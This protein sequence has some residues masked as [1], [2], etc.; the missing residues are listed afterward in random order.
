MRRLTVLIAVVALA[1]GACTGGLD[2]TFSDIGAETD[3]QPGTDSGRSED[4]ATAGGEEAAATGTPTD[5]VDASDPGVSEA[6]LADGRD[7]VYTG[8]V[9]V[10]VADVPVAVEQAI[11]AV[12]RL[13]GLVVGEESVADPEPRTTLTVRVAPAAFRRVLDQLG[14]L[15]EV[16]S[17]RVDAD[18]VTEQVVDLESRIATAEASVARLRALLGEAGDIDDIATLERQLLERETELEVL[19]GRLRTL[20][21]A[22][23]LTTIRVT[24]TEAAAAPAVA[25]AVTGYPGTD[26][27]GLACP[28]DVAPTVERGTEVTVCLEVRNVGDTPLTSIEV[29]DDVLGIG[30]DDVVAVFGDPEG[31]IE[32]GQSIVLAAPI[33][34]ERT[35]QGRTRVTAVPVDAE[36]QPIEARPVDAAGGIVVSAIVPDTPPGFGEGLAG[37]LDVLGRVWQWLVVAAGALVPF[38]GL[39]AVGAAGWW[40]LR[41]ARRRSSAVDGDVGHDDPVAVGVQPG[42]GS[43]LDAGESDG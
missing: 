41:P 18:D 27:L 28:G 29:D 12:E 32:P 16:R 26:D 23:A 34:I 37:S 39:A 35:L 17:Q 13:G 3:D 42:A 14:S 11:R 8:V 43:E 1:A 20:E 2:A 19:R 5:R 36:G 9:R 25:V 10:A 15:G 24:F 21:D 38:L 22:V 6:D 7:M 4:E 33:T 31:V 30:S 40:L